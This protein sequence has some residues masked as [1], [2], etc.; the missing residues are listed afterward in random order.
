[1]ERSSRHRTGPLIVRVPPTWR[2]VKAPVTPS[3]RARLIADIRRKYQD[4]SV[5]EELI[6]MLDLERT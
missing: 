3:A 4:E 6:E 1:M 2:P 5:V